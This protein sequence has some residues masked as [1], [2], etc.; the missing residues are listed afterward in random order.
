MT[1]PTPESDTMTTTEPTPNTI[2]RIDPDNLFDSTD[3]GFCSTVVTPAG[4]RTVYVAGKLAND[5][6]GNFETQVTQSFENL[7]LGLEAGGASLA[8]VVKITCLIVDADAERIS[9]VSQARRDNFANNRPTSTIIPV[10]RLV[11]ENALFEI[12]AI[13]VAP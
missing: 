10:P 11:G 3:L 2:D 4:A 6:D 7:R 1:P 8:T 13:A 12:D 9:I 5:H